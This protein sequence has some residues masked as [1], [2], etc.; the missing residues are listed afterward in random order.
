MKKIVFIICLFSV[1]NFAYSQVVKTIKRGESTPL[2]YSGGSGKVF[3]WYSGSCGGTYVGA[4]NGFQ[5]TPTATTTYYGRWEDGNKVS[6]CL[7]ITV[8][9]ED[10]KQQQ[11]ER[12]RL[13]REAEQKRQQEE[14]D[15]ITRETEQQ[16]NLHISSNTKGKEDFMDCFFDGKCVLYAVYGHRPEY[17]KWL[18]DVKND[19][20]WS[21]INHERRW[22]DLIEAAEKAEF[23][24]L[25]FNGAFNDLAIKLTN[26]P[27][28]KKYL[29]DVKNDK[30][31]SSINH[32]RIWKNLME[33]A[34]LREIGRIKSLFLD[35]SY[36]EICGMLTDHPEYKEY[37]QD[38]KNDLSWEI[39][40]FE[41]RWKL[42]ME[43]VILKNIE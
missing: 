32:E 21:S 1:A 7:T 18:Q 31:W 13:A 34:K 30:R 40:D 11:E 26:H 14:Q 17:K 20:R 38:V 25:F 6:D 19:K 35:G 3:K 33:S 23:L 16:R 24:S 15:R 41:D 10:N 29:Q 22:S 42:L 27:E 28:N 37:L 9:V 2:N 5:V 36:N 4:G 12:D 8:K 43:C 39:I